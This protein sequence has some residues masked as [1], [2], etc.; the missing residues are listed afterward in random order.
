MLAGRVAERPKELRLAGA[1][2]AETE[3]QQQ[4]DGK[5]DGEQCELRANPA[6]TGKSTDH[7]DSHRHQ[8]KNPA[9]LSS[10]E[11]LTATHASSI[12]ES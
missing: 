8:V 3:Q 6:E 11:F 12:A 4:Q 9:P 2:L 10:M 7:G 5:R 1:R